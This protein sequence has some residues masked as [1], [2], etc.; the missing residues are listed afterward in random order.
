MKRI[1][2]AI[3][4]TTA[5]VA[6][7]G[8][9]LAN[10][11]DY[12]TLAREKR[13]I[14]SETG[15][16]KTGPSTRLQHDKQGSELSALDRKARL[17]G[18]LTGMEESS[19]GDMPTIYGWNVYSLNETPFGL[20]KLEGEKF[21]MVWADRFYDSEGTKLLNGFLKDGKIIG[22][23]SRELFGYVMG[24]FNVVYD[25]ETGDIVSSTKLTVKDAPHYERFAY[26]PDDGYVYGIGKNYQYNESKTV[27]MRSDPSDF[28][29][30]EVIADLGEHQN[31]QSLC[32][33]E[34]DNSFYGA[35][36]KGEFARID[37]D[38]TYTPLFV[39]DSDFVP[40]YVGGLL[41]NQKDNL[42]YWNYSTDD[43]SFMATINDMAQQVNVLFEIEQANELSF[44]M[45]TDVWT[46][47]PLQPESPEVARIEFPDGAQTGKIV[48]ALP[49]KH[50]DGTPILS[51]LICNVTLDG[52]GYA[53]LE[54][55]S[56]SELEVT[57]TDLERGIHTFGFL[58]VD[59]G[60]SSSV[61]QSNLF[62][63]Y[64]T[65]KP[66]QNVTMNSVSLKWD[67]VTE[68]VNKGYVDA[69]NV[70]YSISINGEA[71]ATSK[72]TS[73]EVTLPADRPLA[74]YTASVVAINGEYR[75][76]P[77]YS[78]DVVAGESLSLPVDLKPTKAEYGL[79]TVAD[80]NGDGVYWIY[81]DQQEAFLMGYSPEDS[82]CDDWLFLPPF[83]VEDADNTLSLEYEAAIRSAMFNREELEVR[84][85]TSPDPESMTQTLVDHYCPNTVEPKM[86]TINRLFTVPA[87]GTYYIGFHLTSE[88]NQM[89]VLIKNVKIEDNN[90][91]DDSPAAVSG[92]KAVAA[93]QGVLEATVTLTL[94]D[95]KFSGEMLSDDTVINVA[96]SSDV[97]RVETSG[98]PGESISLTVKTV[99]GDN[100]IGAVASIGD[101]RSPKTTVDVYT[102]VW[103]PSHTRITSIST[104]PDMMQT[105]ITWDPVTE[106][107]GGR[108][109]IPE[110]VTYDVYIVENSILGPSWTFYD[111]AGKDTEY[112]YYCGNG[113]PQQV[114]Q[115]GVVANNVAG[116]DGY[117]ASSRDLVGTPYILPMT[118]SFGNGEESVEPW[119]IYTP[120]TSYTAE[121]KIGQISGIG[122]FDTDAETA[123]IAIAPDGSGSKGMIGLPRF[124][125]E[126]MENAKIV[127]DMYVGQ[128]CADIKI[129]GAGYYSTERVTLG[130]VSAGDA[131]PDFRRIEMQLPAGL[132]GQGWVQLYIEAD[133]SDYDDVVI[134]STISLVEG[135]ADGVAS[136]TE[137]RG[138]S[139]DNGNIVFA[140]LEGNAFSVCSLDGKTVMSGT[141][142]SAYARYPVASGIYIVDSGDLRRKVLV[143]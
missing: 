69:D 128:D 23:G 63:G 47:D 108:F 36:L 105:T 112:T 49:D 73:I 13:L 29:T 123:L 101:L 46:D 12:R 115:I 72:E 87:A 10:A 77:S 58:V 14:K 51:K 48:Y 104:T 88:P 30:S 8:S 7:T 17:S 116:N 9:I 130:T 111:N 85:G 110:D 92:L 121:W 44:F 64:D 6:M 120:S 131:S 103:V 86:E 20:Y 59:D 25:F 78:N 129:T 15:S 118:E 113:M 94:P 82:F 99:Q 140:G 18:R 142:K 53:E 106:G 122:D 19:S 57:F 75:S 81:G 84:I 2:T 89:G 22:L 11:S 41:Y 90:I 124:S 16:K 71:Y 114:L 27:F 34:R 24:Y 143:R 80:V 91:T 33:C 107:T 50:V 67:A 56:G 54:G 70:L 127:M 43:S 45:T 38:G 65:P 66:P 32:Y 55:D 141:V 93:E 74:V 137:T 79:C 100:V 135:V 31:M 68:G 28:T 97:D 109:I 117:V 83:R 1:I 138:I 5:M 42:F 61:C 40:T 26:N 139:A 102:G 21:D 62:I 52:N 126:G 37:V 134:I 3:L 133:F 35:N 125:T 132:I 96:V 119:V 98:K 39:L 95:K 4:A 136:I 76:E 60:H